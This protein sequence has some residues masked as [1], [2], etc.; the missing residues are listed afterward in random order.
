[1]R[2]IVI[3]LC[4]AGCSHAPV[5]DLRASGDKAQYFNRDTFECKELARQV[6]PSWTLRFGYVVDECLKGRG[7]SI[8]NN[9]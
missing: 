7:H 5:A 3:F 1:M 6:V 2:I 4:L 8:I 9:W